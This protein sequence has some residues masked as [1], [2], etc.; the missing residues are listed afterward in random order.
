[1]AIYY[2]F[3]GWTWGSRVTDV[4]LEKMNIYQVLIGS[5]H[6]TLVTDVTRY[7]QMLP[8]MTRCE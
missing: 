4:D 1:M 5:N 2:V 6:S 8:D 7:D 3:I